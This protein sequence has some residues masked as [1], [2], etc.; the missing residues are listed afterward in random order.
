V[1]EFDAVALILY[2]PERDTFSILALKGIV[3]QFHVGQEIGRTNTSVG[4]VFDHKHYLL[5]RDLATEGEY[6]NERRLVEEGMHSHCVMPLMV[7]G[8]SLG[9]LNLTHRKVNQYSEDDASFLEAVA[10]Q[11]AL[12]L[13]NMKA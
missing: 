11:V 13:E 2:L 9:T 12:A 6:E 10:V 1:V 8:A 3:R 4:W 5:R 7:R